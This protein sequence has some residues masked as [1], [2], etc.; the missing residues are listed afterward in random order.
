MAVELAGLLEARGARTVVVNCDSMQVYRGMGVLTGA[1]SGEQME[2]VEH[3]LVMEIP[4]DSEYS[5]GQFARESRAAIDDA[6][7]MGRWPLVVGGTGLYLRA[8][9]S[10]LE[11]RPPVDQ[12]IRDEA[13]RKVE[14]LGPAE[15]H[16]TLP[17]RIREWVHPNDR[18]RI[19]RYL[20][21]LEAGET[22]APPTSDG[23]G[24]WT[25]SLRHPTFLFGLVV[26]DPELE[27]R[28]HDRVAEMAA[29]GAGDEARGAISAGLSRTAAQAIGLEEFA[30][31]DLEAAAASHIRFARSQMT[32]MRRMD[33]L[34]PI[35]RDGRT[36]ADLA[37][38]MYGMLV[39]GRGLEAAGPS[40][41]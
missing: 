19:A 10:D 23:G 14:Q 37:S 9:L 40:G 12:A 4:P 36:D 29:A 15:V 33:G 28:V 26:A 22:P 38:E 17:R 5:V 27:V 20:A 41:E 18:K 31:G 1:P 21:L 24:L 25:A 30:R 6:L 16:A 13:E 34:V 39:R 35:E 7:A 8:A 2:R 32:W 11:L 3:R